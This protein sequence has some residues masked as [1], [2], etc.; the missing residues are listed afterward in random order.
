MIFTLHLASTAALF[1]LIWY[2]QIVHYPLYHRIGAVEFP[3]Y[4]FQSTRATTWVVLPLMLAEL[5][6]AAWLWHRAAPEDKGIWLI[7]V[8]LIGAAWAS[9]A[10][11]QVPC[12]LLL[13]AGKDDKVIRRLVLTNWAR[14]IAWSLRLMLLLALWSER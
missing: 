9:T 8:G 3:A 6:T 14:V 5:L 10:I 7:L 13:E 12:H 1:G 11:Y 2:V 4:H